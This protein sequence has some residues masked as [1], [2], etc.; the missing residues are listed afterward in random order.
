MSRFRGRLE[1]LER[2][3]REPVPSAPAPLTG[4]LV[5]KWILGPPALTPRDREAFVATW[6]AGAAAHARFLEA[7]P[8]GKLYR[9]ELARLGLAQPETLAG[10]DVIEELL[11]LTGMPVPGGRA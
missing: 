3:R 7:S 5:L 10:V 8:T 1:R 2:D 9:E 11:K 6:D 4:E